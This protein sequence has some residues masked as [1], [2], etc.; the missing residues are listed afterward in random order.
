MARRRGARNRST[1]ER[2][3]LEGGEK[4]DLSGLSY[5]ELTK[6]IEAGPKPV[7]VPLAPLPEPTERTIIEPDQARAIIEDTRRRFGVMCRY[8][9]PE[10]TTKTAD[11]SSLVP[12]RVQEY[13]RA[14]VF[15]AS[16]LEE[17]QGHVKRSLD[18]LHTS[19]LVAWGKKRI[20]GP[21]TPANIAKRADKMLAW[22][23]RLEKLGRK[24]EAV[25]QRAKAAAIRLTPVA[26]PGSPWLT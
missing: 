15:F 13:L 19:L 10:E 8:Y 1:L 11:A 16:T 23:V 25:Q 14:K 26:L 4:G 22:A 9:D 17:A 21:S 6:R 3:L 2:E 5:E 20:S 18:M 24:D 7:E 12:E